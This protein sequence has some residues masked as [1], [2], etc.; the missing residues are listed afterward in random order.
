MKKLSGII[1]VDSGDRNLLWDR[2]EKKWCELL[3][4]QCCYIVLIL[5]LMASYITEFE[6]YSKASPREVWRDSLYI[7]WN[8]AI[9]SGLNLDDMSEWVSIS[10]FE[11]FIE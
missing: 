1:S 9:Y 3:V 6:H 8:L 11:L 4:C 5:Y 2:E 7:A 10:L